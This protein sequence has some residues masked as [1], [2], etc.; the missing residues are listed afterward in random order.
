MKTLGD[1]HDKLVVVVTGAGAGAGRAIAAR[2]GQ[3]GWRVALLS[4]DP[5]RLEAA[6]HEIERSGG[7]ALAIPTDVADGEA[8]Y[9]ARDKVVQSWGAIDAWVNCAMAT[10]VAPVHELEAKD[11]RRVLEVTLMGYVHG[12]KAALE[13]MRPKNSGAIVQVGSALAYR[14]IPLQSAYCTCKFAIRGF[15]DSLRAE[16]LHERSAITVSMLQMPGMNTIQF[17]W[18]KNLFKHKY[19]P[20]GGVYDPNVAAEAAWRAVHRGPRELWVGFSAIESIVGEMLFPPLLDRIVA[21]SGFNQQIS[22]VPEVPGRPDNLYEAVP[23]DVGARG[24]FSNKAKP[25]ALTIDSTHTRIAAYLGLG[26]AFAA[27]AGAAFALGRRA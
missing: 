12:T 23:R 27:T 22:D 10:L 15:T 4:R 5:D 19:Q 3:E 18:A 6:R 14:A 13:V 25:K 7:E 8:V 17:D 9:A 20:V 21:K 16:L 2:F 24:R 11:F 1:T 26:V